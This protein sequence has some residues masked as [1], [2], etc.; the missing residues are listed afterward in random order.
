[1]NPVDPIE[2]VLR[3]KGK[4]VWSISPA[5]TVYEAIKTMSAKGIGALLVMEGGKLVGIVSERDYAWK[6]ILRDRASNHTEVREIMSSPVFSV[7]PK[8]T[9]E[10]CMRIM[11]EEKIRHLPV[12]EGEKIAGMVSIRDLV[13]WI[14]TSHEETIGHLEDYIV[15]RYPG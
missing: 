4:E 9:V 14:I 13:N 5:A 12:V 10:Q 8:H 2:S 1:M 11:S 3:L 6:V 7:T 15:G